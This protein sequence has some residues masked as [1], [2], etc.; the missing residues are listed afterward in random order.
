[1]GKATEDL[2]NEHEAILNVLTILDRVIT[3]EGTKDASLINFGNELVYFLRIFA[4]K[5]H[6]GKEENFLFTELIAKGVQNEGGPIG[7]MLQEHRQGREFISLMAQSL[8]SKDLAGFKTGA[9]RYR[10]LIRSHIDKENN[11]LFPM[12]D[13]LL[14]EHTQAE[15]FEKFENHEETVI[16]HG[17]HEELHA[18][19][20]RWDKEF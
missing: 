12:A 2:K 8:Q 11:I 13:N 16:G 9:A 3:E 6:H 5:C 15:L 17:V 19:I 18:M 1:M 10:D 14:D 4:D 20:N 7:V